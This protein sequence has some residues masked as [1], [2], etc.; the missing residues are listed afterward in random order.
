[1]SHWAPGDEEPAGAPTAPIGLPGDNGWTMW[2]SGR[3]SITGC[4]DGP[5]AAIERAGGPRRP[6]RWQPYCASHARQRGVEGVDGTLVWTAD[7]LAPPSRDGA[8]DAPRSMYRPP[9]W[10]G[11]QG[12]PRITGG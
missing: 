3:C 5:L 12:T 6:A 4:P 1:M 10:G 7:F 11:S 9:S 8:R 2:D